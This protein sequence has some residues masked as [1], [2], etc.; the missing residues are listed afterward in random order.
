MGD[1]FV[2]AAGNASVSRVDFPAGADGVIAVARGPRA[3]GDVYAPASSF[4]GPYP[5]GLWFRGSG[6]SFS[7]PLVGGGAALAIER[8]RRQ[9]VDENWIEQALVPGHEHG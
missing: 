5:G 3:P 1:V 2:A 9:G 8:H 6:S 4:A 7:T